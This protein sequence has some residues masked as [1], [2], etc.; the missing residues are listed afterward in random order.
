MNAA[1]PMETPL[2][3]PRSRCAWRTGEELL[4]GATLTAMVAL[5]LAEVLLR[6]AGRPGLAGSGTVVQHLTLVAGMLGAALAARDDR[7]LAFSGAAG[8]LTARRQRTARWVGHALSVAVT[9]L[10]A[11]AAV[12][13]VAVERTSGAR[14]LDRLPLW[15]VQ[16][17]LPLGFIVIGL[18]LLFRAGPDWRTRTAAALLAGGLMAL[19]VWPPVAHEQLILPGIAGLLV[20]A[21]LGAPIYV[22]IGGAALLLFQ[23]ADLPIAAIPV[24]HYRLVTNPALPSIPLFTLAGCLMAEG[25]AARR[26]VG[27]SQALAGWFRGGPAVATALLCAFFTALTGGSGVTILALGGLLMPVLR[28]ARYSERD[29]LGLLTGAGSLGILLPPCLPVILYAV[30]AKVGIREMF[31]GG[32]VPGLLLIGLT[33]AWGIHAGRKAQVAPRKFDPVAARRA[34]WAAK[35]EL[36]LPVVA[37]GVLFSGWATPV[38]AAA[39]TATYAFLIEVV[40]HRDLSLRRDGARVMAETG[41]L[42]GGILLVLGVALGLTNYLID[43]QAPDLLAAWAAAHVP[44]RGLF[45][46]GLNAVLLV[47]GGIV[48]IYA[49]IVVVVPLLLPVGLKL[50]L[51]PV[52]LGV[53]FLA[54]ME[55]GF[56]APPIGLNLLLASSR[57]RK[58]VAETARA[59]LPVLGI[60]FLGVLLITYVPAL[61]LTLPRWLTPTLP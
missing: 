59:V 22:P 9:F 18:R 35:W 58:P 41:L 57:L 50:G 29:A 49:A 45:L 55:L 5:P 21:A 40:V 43:A 60:L 32:L 61:T 39:V 27:L 47:V 26:L 51:D 36:L 38:E 17:I 12:Q 44:S 20:A 37:L 53:I 2:A 31:L 52:H 15:L 46:L 7:L 1:I 14:L 33:I 42:V 54:N 56:L 25:G 10:L 24:E 19:A 34:V 23:G 11:A 6:A 13:F 30:V 48:E 3:A 16:A 28:A 8:F 4:T